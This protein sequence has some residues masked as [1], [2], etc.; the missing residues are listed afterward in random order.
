MI[1]RNGITIQHIS[2]SACTSLS[3]W[4]AR[5]SKFKSKKADFRSRV[6]ILR[7]HQGKS[8]LI[9]DLF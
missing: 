4:V 7:G 5:S 1:R 3:T 9:M 8:G 6:E 2:F